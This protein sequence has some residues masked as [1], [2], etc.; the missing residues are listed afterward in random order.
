MGQILLALVG[1][2]VCLVLYLLKLNWVL[3]HTPQ[4]VVD[5]AGEPLTREYIKDVFERVKK[6]G[7]GSEEK[8]PPRKDRRYIIVGGS[9]KF[10]QM[11]LR[12]TSMANDG[13]CRIPWRPDHFASLGHGNAA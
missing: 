2:V 8:L 3:S 9:G 4:E 6:D 7:F 12:G 5:R 10:A 1:G 11:F 13:G